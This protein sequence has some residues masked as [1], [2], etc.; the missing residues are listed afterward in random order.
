LNFLCPNH[1]ARFFR[2]DNAVGGEASAGSVDYIAIYDTALS[3]QEIATLV[4]AVPEPATQ[5]LMLAGLAGVLAVVR[6]RS[7]A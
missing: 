1:T 4:P 5:G 3:A 2:D 6:R 7:Q